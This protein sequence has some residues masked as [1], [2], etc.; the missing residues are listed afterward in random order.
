M[1]EDRSVLDLLRANYYVRH[2]AWRT[3]T[4]F[5]LYGSWFRRITFG[6][7]AVRGLLRR[8]AS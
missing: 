4:V 7:D 5:P 1:R 3:T 8:E 2:G 6:E